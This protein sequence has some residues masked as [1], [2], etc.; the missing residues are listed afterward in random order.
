VNERAG[1]AVNERAGAAVTPDESPTVAMPLVKVANFAAIDHLTGVVQQ[2]SGPA[3]N[4]VIA[5]G[6]LRAPATGEHA[7]LVGN[8]LQGGGTDPVA[9]VDIDGDVVLQGNW[10]TQSA[11]SSSPAIEV[12]AASVSVQGNRV[13]GA[14]YAMELRVPASAGAVIGNLVSGEIRLGSP[15]AGL[16]APWNML[17][18][19]VP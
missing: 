15:P 10:L 13:A 6:L 5:G 19:Q 2:I 17:N 7:T 9:Q 18:P 11:G 14:K 3:F 12:S 1:A 4:A 16:A 8:A